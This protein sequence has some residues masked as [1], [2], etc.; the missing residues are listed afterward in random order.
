MKLL[1]EL[2]GEHPELSLVELSSVAEAIEGTSP[3]IDVDSSTAMIDSETD[4]V[5]FGQRMALCHRINEVLATGSIDELKETARSLALGGS[6]AV[7]CRKLSREWMEPCSGIERQFGEILAATHSIDLGNPSAVIRILLG[8]SAHLTIQRAEVDRAGY[9]ARKVALRPF[10]YPISLHP[11]FARL[12]VN[13]TKV[14]SGETLLDPFCGTGGIVIEAT[15]VGASAAG[16]DLRS[17][18]VEGCRDNLAKFGLS[19]ELFTTDVRKLEEYIQNVDA[20]ATDPPY[21]RS[22]STNGDIES[23]YSESFSVFSRILKKGGLLAIILPEKRMI[24][25]GEEHMD[26]QVS[27]SLR[28]HK[29]LTRHFCLYKN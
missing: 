10:F 29:S 13:M 3:K 21:G 27:H 28:V 23:L 14:R 26:L 24:K 20:I 8:K 25:T 7:R 18:M 11:R 19:A 15:L 17:D 16:S 2:S 22:T 1:F 5:E 6:V 9:E 12:L 4:P